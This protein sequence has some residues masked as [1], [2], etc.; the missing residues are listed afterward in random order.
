MIF[1]GLIFMMAA[2]SLLTL[3]IVVEAVPVAQQVRAWQ[4]GADPVLPASL[5]LALAVVFVVCAI[6]T[7]LPLQ[8][9]LRRLSSLE[10]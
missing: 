8:L 4:S 6:A 9:G 2:V 5:L 7:I 3:I 10:A 1:G